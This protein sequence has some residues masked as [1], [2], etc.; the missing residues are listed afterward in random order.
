MQEFLTVTEVADYLGL[1]PDTVYRTWKRWGLKAY[2][3]GK[4]IKFRQRDID[5]W[6]EGHEA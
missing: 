2:R 5:N 4:A 1:H 6:L 3:V